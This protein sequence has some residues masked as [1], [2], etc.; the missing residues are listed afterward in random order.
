MQVNLLPALDCQPLQSS[1]A[2][3]VCSCAVCFQNNPRASSLPARPQSHCASLTALRSL[4]YIYG[5]PGSEPKAGGGTRCL[6]AAS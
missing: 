6:V 5:S 3:I 4:L 2:P 1:L